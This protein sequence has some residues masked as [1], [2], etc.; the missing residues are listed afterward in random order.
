MSTMVKLKPDE[1]REM[2]RNA[3]KRPFAVRMEDGATYKITHPDFAR[4]TADTL[5]IAASPDQDLGGRDFV[6]C[7]LEHDSRLEFLKKKARAK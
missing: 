2:I 6:L 1:I 4:C 5:I 3:D 7:Y